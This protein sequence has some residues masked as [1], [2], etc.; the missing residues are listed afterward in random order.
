M[1]AKYHPE[2][3][4]VPRKFQPA[5]TIYVKV[6]PPKAP[7]PE[8]LFLNIILNCLGVALLSFIAFVVFASCCKVGK[9]TVRAGSFVA[10]KGR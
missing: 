4:I 3:P 1:I 2:M 5:P 10:Q 7:K 8:S 6:P 9:I